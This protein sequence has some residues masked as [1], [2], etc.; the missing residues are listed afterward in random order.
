MESVPRRAPKRRRKLIRDRILAFLSE[1][2]HTHEIAA[3]TGERRKKISGHLHQMLALKLVERIGYGIYIKAGGLDG[4]LPATSHKRPQPVRDQ[5]LAFLTEPRHA[6]EIA[7]HTGRRTA[8]IT[9]HLRAML[10][11][12]LVE[13]VAYGVYARAEV[14]CSPTSARVYERPRPLSDEIL[15]LLYEPRHLDDI[16]TQLERP[17]SAVRR[18]LSDM[19]GRGLVRAVE[20]EVF[21]R[22]ET[23]PARLPGV[24]ASS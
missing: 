3:H 2:R 5:I 18:R 16:A 14:P 21:R 11:L 8:T 24:I 4:P 9:G 10:V 13:R 20:P 15:R 1:P 23:N 22:M 7:A 6:H 12:R 17:A 19:L